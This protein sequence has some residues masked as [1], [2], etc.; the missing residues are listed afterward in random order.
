MVLSK[1]A[2][3][4]I[5]AL[6]IGGIGVWFVV[7]SL[8]S[9]GWDP[10]PRSTRALGTAQQPAVPMVPKAGPNASSVSAPAPSA[11][12][13]EQLPT[14]SEE[15]AAST[16]ELRP[17]EAQR[18][19]LLEE[20][21]SYFALNAETIQKLAVIFGTSKYLGQGLPKVT[22]HPLSRAEC[23]KTRENLRAIDTDALACGAKNMARV[24]S[25]TKGEGRQAAPI[26]IDRFEFPNI[27]C[28]YPLTWVRSS[29]ASEICQALGKRLCD[30]HEWEG[31]C[32]GDLRPAEEEYFF[33]KPRF[34]AEYY[35]NLRRPVVWSYGPTKNHALCATGGLK[36]PKCFASGY[37]CGS[38]TYPAGS[39][40]ECKNVLGVYDLHGN[41]AEHM[42]MP[43]QPDEFTS[44]GGL[45]RTEM[46]G[47]W[48]V[49]QQK[50]THPDDCRWR[51]PDWH[52][53]DIEDPN[54]H[55]NYHLG[56]RCCKSLAP[57]SP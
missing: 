13:L 49:F 14:F 51:A 28:E 15:A 33:G 44:K 50:E 30:A 47:S 17:V 22:V 40:P 16:R 36:S 37:S 52:A 32:A 34:Q 5:M 38:N 54:S 42:N 7:E 21:H 53:T 4:G 25:K 48:F 35:S 57:G 6:A 39:F 24:T 55:H 8:V 19:A 45:G 31:A 41:A 3:I 29:A 1:S 27:P 11:P 43:N 46:K 2:I 18:E 26:C 23:L 10:S 20:L 56:F 12:T 9:R